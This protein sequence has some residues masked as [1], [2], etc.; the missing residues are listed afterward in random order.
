[1]P[2][3]Q[4]QEKASHVLA[5]FERNHAKLLR[6]IDQTG[7]YTEEERELIL[8]EAAKALSEEQV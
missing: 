7:R 1:M 3:K 8:R 2:V 6:E 4:I 5:Y